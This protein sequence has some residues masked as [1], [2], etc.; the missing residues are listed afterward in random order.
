[1]DR[2]RSRSPLP[3]SKG[4]SWSTWPDS[5]SKQWSKHEWQ[6]QDWS[7]SPWKE[8]W[9]RDSTTWQSSSKAYAQESR[10]LLLPMHT[11]KFKEDAWTKDEMD[12]SI[13]SEFYGNDLY[14]DTNLV[15]GIPMPKRVMPTEWSQKH[16]ISG[17]PIEE[18]AV[19]DVIFQGYRNWTLRHLAMGRPTDFTLSKH[20]D[21]ARL[22]YAINMSMKDSNLEDIVTKW[23]NSLVKPHPCESEE[24]KRNI[25]NKLGEHIGKIINDGCTD[26]QLYKK[27]QELEQEL[28]APK[29]KLHDGPKKSSDILP[30][31]DKYGRTSEH[32]FMQHDAPSNA[33]AKEVQ[34]WITKILTKTQAKMMNKIMSDIKTIVNEKVSNDVAR[35]EVLKVTLVDHGC[36]I[37]LA[38][39]FERDMATKVLAALCAKDQ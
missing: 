28:T 33:Q 32:K 1:M 23:N 12:K 35:L 25:V 19:I 26:S 3:R 22:M 13:P 11:S 30:G 39:K 36:P 7:T 16:G 10:P 21:K 31:L 37:N 17:K 27:I 18:V 4:D 29:L 24:D 15:F 34:A 5:D 2:R 8:S 38:A 9:D 14:H 20:Y 6:D